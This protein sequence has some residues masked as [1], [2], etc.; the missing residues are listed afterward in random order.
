MDTSEVTRIWINVL[1]PTNLSTRSFSHFISTSL[2]LPIPYYR[3]YLILYRLLLQSVADPIFSL[4]MMLNASQV[5]SFHQFY[6]NDS[7]FW[8]L[9]RSFMLER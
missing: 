2:L 4:Y 6:C 3:R 5:L 8:Y 1:P 7:P 9:H